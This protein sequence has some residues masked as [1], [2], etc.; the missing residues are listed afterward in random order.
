MGGCLERPFHIYYCDGH[1]QWENLFDMEWEVVYRRD[2]PPEQQ[3]PASEDEDV[4][5]SEE[6]SDDNGDDD[7]EESEEYEEEYDDMDDVDDQEQEHDEEWDDDGSDE[8]YDGPVN[9]EH[10]KCKTGKELWDLLQ[11]Q[12]RENPVEAAKEAAWQKRLAELRAE[13]ALQSSSPAMP[14]ASPKKR[15]RKA[16]APAAK[17][18]KKAAPAVKAAPKRAASGRA[19]SKAASK[20]IFN[21]EMKKLE[22][23]IEEADSPCVRCSDGSLPGTTLRPFAPPRPQVI[24]PQSS[25]SYSIADPGV[26]IYCSSVSC[27]LR[28]PF[29]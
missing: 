5:D 11:K 19:A 29:T 9:P 2:P 8:D 28:T 3:A 18:K 14:R 4:E 15:A 24:R 12:R 16:A 17:K 20:R 1:R 6:C 27:C 10:M 13:D 26:P 22:K 7:A 25:A 21:S 23:E